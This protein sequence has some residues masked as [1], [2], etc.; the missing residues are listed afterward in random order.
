M[1]SYHEG[2]ATAGCESWKPHGVP[3][4]AGNGN[5]VLVGSHAGTLRLSASCVNS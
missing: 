5:L 1:L 2:N 4:G 3:F